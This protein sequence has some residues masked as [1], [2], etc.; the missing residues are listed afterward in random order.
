MILVLLVGC[1]TESTSNEETVIIKIAVNNYCYNWTD[2]WCYPEIHN[3][4]TT[5]TCYTDYAT[6]LNFI[7]DKILCE[8]GVNVTYYW[9]GSV[10]FKAVNDSIRNEVCL[11]EKTIQEK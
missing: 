5:E 4:F 1:N 10:D 8:D 6:V 7:P 2:N 9:F 11:V 3:N